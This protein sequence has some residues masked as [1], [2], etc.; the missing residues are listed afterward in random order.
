MARVSTAVLV[1]GRGSNLAALFE[2]AKDPAYPAEISLVISNEPHAAAIDLAA[3][4]GADVALVPH[5]EQP[6]RR[7]FETM[8]QTHILESG[9]TLVCL[10]GFMRILSSAFVAAWSGRLLNIHPSLLPAFPGLDTHRRALEAGVKLAGCTVHFVNNE[11]DGGPIVGPAAVPV[12]PDDTEASLAARVLAA[13]HRLYPLC[14]GLVASGQIA[15]SDGKLV[16]RGSVGEGFLMNP[17]G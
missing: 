17:V 8:V 16:S 6:S 7:A 4:A 1:S 13:E 11:L 15:L 12:A 9:C 2:A 10:A 5:R 14:L 3:A